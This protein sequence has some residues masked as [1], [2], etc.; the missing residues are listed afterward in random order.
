M[1]ELVFHKKNEKLV[2]LM[3]GEREY[4]CMQHSVI[5]F[6][7]QTKNYYH[8]LIS[9]C[10]AMYFCSKKFGTFKL[11]LSTT[12]LTRRRRATDVPVGTG[13]VRVSVFYVDC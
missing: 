10:I 3:G 12:I 2:F 5:L 6:L 8:R 7:Y 1:N 4:V 9:E 11:Q 13:A